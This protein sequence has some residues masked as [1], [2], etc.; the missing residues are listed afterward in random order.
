MQNLLAKPIVSEWVIV[1]PT[2]SVIGLFPNQFHRVAGGYY[3]CL[4]V[5]AESLSLQAISE[6]PLTI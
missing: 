5:V 4:R 3:K 2:S 6:W 1:E